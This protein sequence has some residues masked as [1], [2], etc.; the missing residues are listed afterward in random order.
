MFTSEYLVQYMENLLFCFIVEYLKTIK[1]V[2]PKLWN[3]C[4]YFLEIFANYQS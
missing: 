2:M 4:I 3:V 1:V